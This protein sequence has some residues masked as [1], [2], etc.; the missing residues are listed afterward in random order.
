MTHS[1]A[2]DNRTI[3]STR[4]AAFQFF[5]LAWTISCLRNCQ[6]SFS[7]CLGKFT[8]FSSIRFLFRN[9]M[10]CCTSFEIHTR[11]TRLKFMDEKERAIVSKMVKIIGVHLLHLTKIKIFSHAHAHKRAFSFAHQQIYKSNP[12]LMLDNK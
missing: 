3:R 1:R 12:K 8:S 2:V 4:W 6:F 10:M 9:M 5:S 7:L 11:L